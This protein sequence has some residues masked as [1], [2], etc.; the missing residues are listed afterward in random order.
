MRIVLGS[1]HAGY[2][3][4]QVLATHLQQAG[5]VVADVGTADTSSCDY[6]DFAAP[7]C[8]RVLAGQADRAILVCGSGI[9]ISISANKIP[10]MRCALVYNRDTARLAKEHNDAQAIALGARFIPAADALAMVDTYLG[11]TFEARH[12]RRIDK[13][14]ALEHPTC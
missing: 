9:G 4:K 10:G 6:P 2:G 12:Q 14:R 7:A 5:H 8:R 1:D 11:A 13:I 3:L